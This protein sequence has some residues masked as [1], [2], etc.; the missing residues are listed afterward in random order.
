MLLNEL[1]SGEKRNAAAGSLLGPSV[2][3]EPQT[4]C[5]AYMSH[6]TAISEKVN[7]IYSRHVCI[8]CVCVRTCFHVSQLTVTAYAVICIA[9][10]LR[11][12]EREGVILY[13]LQYFLATS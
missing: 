10:S 4:R 2:P 13:K 8:V 1:A 5:P 6:S 11:M 3:L 12:L 9:S 7:Q